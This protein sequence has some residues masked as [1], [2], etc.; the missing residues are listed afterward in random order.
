MYSRSLDNRRVQA[1]LPTHYGGSAFRSDGT[2]TPIPVI[3]EH[4]LHPRGMTDDRN[5]ASL[6]ET[7][8]AT[9]PP[10]DEIGN[11]PQENIILETRDDAFSVNAPSASK[12]DRE[13]KEEKEGAFLPRLL[14]GM[15]PGVREDDLLLLLLILLL[16]REEGNEDVLVLLAFLLFAK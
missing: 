10:S 11:E 12:R 3:R 15:L 5:A 9:T 8:E 14:D 13:K 7:M 16:S 2:P 1:T 6:A 4:D